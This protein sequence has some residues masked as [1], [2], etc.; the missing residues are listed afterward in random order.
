MVKIY[1]RRQIH[2]TANKILFYSAVFLIV[3]LGVISNAR[4]EYLGRLGG[5]PFA[6]DSTANPFSQIAN[7]FSP[8]SPNNPFGPYG[9]EFSPYSPYNEFATDVPEI[10]GTADE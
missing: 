6:P 8:K 7:P 2:D 3:S 9:N 4:A 10:Y 1:L 5:N